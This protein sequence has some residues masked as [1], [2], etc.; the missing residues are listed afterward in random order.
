MIFK[1]NSCFYMKIK[2]DLFHKKS[3]NFNYEIA[4]N[5]KFV[6]ANVNK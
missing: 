6:Q 5:K 3:T 4:Y 2:L 1:Q